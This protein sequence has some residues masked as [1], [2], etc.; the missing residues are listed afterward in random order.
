MQSL[1][2][3][4]V[5]FCHSFCGFVAA[6]WWFVVNCSFSQR[7]YKSFLVCAF[8]ESCT[9]LYACFYY[10]YTVSMDC[11]VCTIFGGCTQCSFNILIFSTSF[12]Q[13]EEPFACYSMSHPHQ[14]MKLRSLFVCEKLFKHFNLF[15]TFFKY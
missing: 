10:T 15:K 11:I 3:F 14:H 4:N 8:F 12:I 9:L 5:S 2:I 7:F 1:F 6:A 13:S